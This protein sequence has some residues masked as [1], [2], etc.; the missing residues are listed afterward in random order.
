[1]NC[2]TFA[3]DQR[4][5]KYVVVFSRYQGRLLFSRHR[6]LWEES[7]AEEFTLTPV[8]GYRA[9][10]GDSGANGVVFTAQITQLGEMPS[11]EMECVRLFDRLPEPL[12]YP[13]ITPVLWQQV[14]AFF[15]EQ[16]NQAGQTQA[17]E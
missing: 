4:D 2:E 8:C 13:G 17:Q 3:L 10:E 12:T 7:G 1:M 11:H 6:E 14:K 5:Y 16:G 9:W 15:P